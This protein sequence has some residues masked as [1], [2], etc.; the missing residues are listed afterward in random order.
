MHILSHHLLQFECIVEMFLHR[1]FPNSTLFQVCRL[2][3]VS[4]E[5]DS[6]LVSNGGDL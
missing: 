4:I 3:T 6:V 2:I 1:N 5:V